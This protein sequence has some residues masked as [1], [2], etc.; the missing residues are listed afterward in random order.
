MET[1]AGLSILG[2]RFGPRE[3]MRRL[4]ASVT[5]QG[6]T[7]FARIDHGAGAAEAGLPL[8][9][10]ELLRPREAHAAARRLCRPRRRSASSSR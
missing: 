7:V 6:I 5:E 3:T 1:P 2:S 8:P 10:T 4:I 9:T